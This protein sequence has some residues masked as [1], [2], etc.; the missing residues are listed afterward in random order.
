MSLLLPILPPPRH[1]SLVGGSLVLPGIISD[2]L[3]KD[4]APVSE[5]PL[6]PQ[7]PHYAPKAKRV[8]FLYMSGGVSH[9]E[10]FDHKPKLAADAGKQYKGRTL[11]GPQFKFQ[12]YGQSGIEVSELFPHMSQ[13]RR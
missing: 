11:L 7:L 9:L 5:N 6:A 3:A 2:L 10:S 13:V 8:I 4:A 1:Q 12:K